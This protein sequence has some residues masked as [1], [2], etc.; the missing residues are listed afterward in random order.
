[1]AATSYITRDALKKALVQVKGEGTGGVI[2]QFSDSNDMTMLAD[3]L[4][5]KLCS[6]D[7]LAIRG[8]D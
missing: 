4:W 8:V 3:R 5:A 6:P 1:M 7:T 2:S